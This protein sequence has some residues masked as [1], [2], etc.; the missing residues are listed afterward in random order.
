M[1]K[2]TKVAFSLLLVVCMLIS[3]M[4]IATPAIAV[5][6]DNQASEL[7][8]ETLPGEAVAADTAVLNEDAVIVEEDT[9]LRGEYEK[10]FFMSDGSYQVALYNEPVHKME[11]GEW[12]EID[13]TLTLKTATDGTARV[14]HSSLQSARPLAVLL[15][16]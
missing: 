5:G 14:R 1:K 10:H 6:T 3:G 9:A 16:R 8:T 7:I 12:V 13:N 15:L 4:P 2:H 11:G